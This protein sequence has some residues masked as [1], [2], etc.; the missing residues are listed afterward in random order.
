MLA[1]ALVMI[2][3]VTGPTM[4]A[5]NW[6]AIKKIEEVLLTDEPNSRNYLRNMEFDPIL[7]QGYSESLQF[8]ITAEPLPDPPLLSLDPAASEAIRR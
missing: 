8:S 4:H 2:S 5:T 7:T 1:S 6:D 3:L